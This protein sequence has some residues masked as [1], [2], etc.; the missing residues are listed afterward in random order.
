MV[1]VKASLWPSCSELC[2]VKLVVWLLHF[3]F[4]L[5]RQACQAQISQADD[6]RG[7]KIIHRETVRT[8]DSGNGKPNLQD[9]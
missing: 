4:N 9:P 6:V 1:L 3:K 5:D 2:L 7:T 8:D